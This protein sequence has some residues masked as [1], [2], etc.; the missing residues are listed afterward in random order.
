[1]MPIEEPKIFTPKKPTGL[2]LSPLSSPSPVFNRS[3]MIK[4][5]SASSD[6]TS[7]KSGYSNKA[8]ALISELFEEDQERYKHAVK[9]ISD[10]RLGILT[11]IA[12]KEEKE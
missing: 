10:E 7:V 11:V 4:P 6:N 3:T 9:R 2:F 12:T 5:D 8:K 1:M